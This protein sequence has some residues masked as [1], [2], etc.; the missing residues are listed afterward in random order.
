MQNSKINLMWE[1][2]WTIGLAKLVVDERFS[3][4]KTDSDSR[5]VTRTRSPMD[6][7]YT[8]VLNDLFSIYVIIIWSA[9]YF[10]YRHLLY[11]KLFK[12]AL[13][14]ETSTHVHTQTAHAKHTHTHTRI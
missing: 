13:H 12:N 9:L 5:C 7:F 4:F 6:L 2:N 14:L 1:I 3:S 10:V 8:H 11:L